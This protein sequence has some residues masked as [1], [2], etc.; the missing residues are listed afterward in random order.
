MSPVTH[1]W[2]RGLAATSLIAALALLPACGSD[3]SSSAE[4][5]E[6]TVATLAHTHAD[7]ET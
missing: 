2:L 6:S 4:S 3:E 1:P 5:D 7:G